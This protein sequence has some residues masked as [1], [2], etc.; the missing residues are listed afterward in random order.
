M[1]MANSPHAECLAKGDDPSG[2]SESWPG[3]DGYAAGIRGARFSILQ[4]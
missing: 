4:Q 3:R 1:A 2:A